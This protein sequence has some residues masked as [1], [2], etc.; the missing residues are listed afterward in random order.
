VCRA[1]EGPGCHCFWPSRAWSRPG[2]VAR[3]VL[4]AFG[5]SIYNVAS[6]HGKRCF[7]C[8]SCGELLGGSEHGPPLLLLQLQQLSAGTRRK[9]ESTRSTGSW[10][11]ALVVLLRQQCYSI[12]NGEQAA[13]VLLDGGQT[14][15]TCGDN[16]SGSSATRSVKVSKRLEFRCFESFSK[17]ALK[18]W[19]T[20]GL[21]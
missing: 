3:P 13:A 2:C 4:L 9:M 16:C 15:R 5:E 11:M 18:P 21:V 19:R 20:A 10:I 7:R 6:E 12:M 17:L 8:A 1:C 14:A